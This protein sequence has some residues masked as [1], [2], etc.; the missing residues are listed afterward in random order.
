MQFAHLLK[1]HW[2]DSPPGGAA[3]RVIVIPLDTGN[4]AKP[5]YLKLFHNT[6]YHRIRN[7]LINAQEDREKAL[8]NAFGEWVESYYVAEHRDFLKA[9]TKHYDGPQRD[10][11][12]RIAEAMLAGSPIG[13]FN[14]PEVLPQREQTE[15]QEAPLPKRG[16]KKKKEKKVADIL[17]ESI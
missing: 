1:P 2:F 11:V 13:L 8:H 9:L 3:V 5:A 4:G 6:E 14:P 10:R 12:R 7:Y 15:V 16:K 17:P